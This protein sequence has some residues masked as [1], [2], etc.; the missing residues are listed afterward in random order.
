MK[1]SIIYLGLA[2]ITFSNVALASNETPTTV[3]AYPSATPLCNAI[4]KGDFA[5]VKKFVEYGADVNE[6]S[7]DMTPLMIAAR[8]N[9]I[10]IMNYLLSKGADV[11]FR[12]ENGMTA[13]KCAHASNAKEA[14]ALLRE[15][16]ARK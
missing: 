10:E 4:S 7:N 9:N 11:N 8:Y 6:R 1:K 14:E 15:K 5:T 13:L 16:G 3:S 2:L 12:N